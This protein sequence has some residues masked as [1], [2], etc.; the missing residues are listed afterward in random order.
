M[1]L[2][3]T[4]FSY[5]YYNNISVMWLLKF[6]CGFLFSYNES[7]SLNTFVHCKAVLTSVT[8]HFN[9]SFAL[10]TGFLKLAQVVKLHIF[11]FHLSYLVYENL[12]Q[13]ERERKQKEKQF[14][15]KCI[16]L[17]IFQLVL[18]EVVVL[19]RFQS[20]HFPKAVF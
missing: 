9:K 15:T 6:D 7:L 2:W 1:Q 13:R 10:D 4:D 5:N 19:K 12:I 16:L 3:F 8:L 14:L 17:F 18:Y 11:F 20:T